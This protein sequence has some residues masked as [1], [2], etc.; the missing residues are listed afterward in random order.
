MMK[1]ERVGDCQRG[2][3]LTEVAIVSAIV[4]ILA[5]V[6]VPNLISWRRSQELQNAASAI[7]SAMY[8]ARTTSIGERTNYTLALDY[9]NNSY[10]VTRAGGAPQAGTNLGAVDVYSDDSDVLCPAL[11]DQDVVFRPN[12]TT[13]SA[14]YEAAYLKSQHASITTRYRVKVLGPT[15]KVAVEKWMGGTWQS[16]Y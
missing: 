3:T 7:S 16:A 1:L 15:G 4:G 13:D 8:T 10:T 6:A 9:A 14:G 5:T 11:S 2:F 12:S